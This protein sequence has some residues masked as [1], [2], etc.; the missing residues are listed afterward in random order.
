MLPYAARRLVSK[1]PEVVPSF[2]RPGYKYEGR[3]RV[4]QGTALGYGILVMRD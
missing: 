2:L 4:V 3:A 1:V